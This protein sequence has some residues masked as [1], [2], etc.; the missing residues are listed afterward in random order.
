MTR[1]DEADLFAWL[2][3][4]AGSPPAGGVGETA[5]ETQ[6]F[7]AEGPAHLDETR[8]ARIWEEIMMNASLPAAPGATHRTTTNQRSA[9]RTESAHIRWLLPARTLKWAPVVNGAAT[10]ILLVAIAAGFLSLQGR[11]VP[12]DQPTRMAYTLG[13]TTGSGTPV[14]QGPRECAA[15]PFSHT[16]P[17]VASSTIGGKVKDWIQG[18]GIMVGLRVDYLG[19][20]IEGENS[21]FVWNEAG[22]V[23]SVTGSRTDV[24]PPS[25]PA[26]ILNEWIITPGQVTASQWTFPTPGCWDV[27]VKIG[28]RAL[29]FTARVMPEDQHVGKAAAIA[30][31]EANIPGPIPATCPVSTWDGPRRTGQGADYQ[32]YVDG[33]GI[34]LQSSDTV[35]AVGQNDLRWLSRS[36]QNLAL[37]GVRLD[38]PGTIENIV[39]Y[40]MLP[41]NGYPDYW[42]TSLA[43]PQA[44][45]WRLTATAGDTRLTATIYV[46]PQRK[47]ATS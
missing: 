5:A 16:A 25:K 10:L 4:P 43:F 1:S 21:V 32:F 46:F 26:V 35:Y 17:P 24:T 22:P 41:G 31:R 28:S 9:A 34:A 33:N 44:G 42:M 20:W 19:E 6:S 18:D 37:T 3:A 30:R 7:L 39:P 45:C 40:Q 13:T 8:K 23:V 38:A 11:G 36:D 29:R 12:P 15:T 47:K 2:D 27:T 14:A